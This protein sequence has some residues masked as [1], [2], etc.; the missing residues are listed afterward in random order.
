MRLNAHYLKRYKDIT[1]L[2][3]KYGQLRTSS[4]LGNDEVLGS[5]NG[6]SKHE[7]NGLPDDLE[8]LGPTFVKLGQLLSSRPEDR[9]S[10]V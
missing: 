6:F 8:R 2:F 7:A 3:L 5:Y 1:I 4:K 9:K 10:V